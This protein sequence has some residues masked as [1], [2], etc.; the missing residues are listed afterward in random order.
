MHDPEACGAVS[1]SADSALTRRVRFQVAKCALTAG[2][3]TGECNR[4]D[5]RLSASC[6]RA[7]SE[8]SARPSVSGQPQQRLLCLL[9]PAA[10]QAGERRRGQ[11]QIAQSQLASLDRKPRQPAHAIRSQLVPRI[12]PA[13]IRLLRTCPR[14][15]YGFPGATRCGAAPRGRGEPARP[16]SVR[17]RSELSGNADFP[18]S[19]KAGMCGSVES[20][21]AS[22]REAA[23]RSGF[24]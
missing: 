4:P 22:R 7:V 15:S 8:R 5:R 17:S 3:R 24:S 6:R 11:L 1:R 12:D 9:V 21:L 16:A 2:A 23:S 13:C 20:T 10:P 14:S 18:V 19:S